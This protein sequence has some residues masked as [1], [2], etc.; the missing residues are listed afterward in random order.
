[1]RRR[2]FVAVSSSALYA[3][4]EAHVGLASAWAQSP[5]KSSHL[6]SSLRLLTTSPISVM[7][8]FYE[9]T[10]GL[11]ILKASESNLLIQAG[12]ST[13]TFEKIVSDARPFYHFAFNIPENKIEQAFAWQRNRTPIVHPNPTGPR[14]A[15]VHFRHWNAHS[16]FF[17]D[18]AGNLLEYIARHDLKNNANGDFSSNDILYVSEIGFIVDE[19]EETGNSIQQSLNLGSYRPSE[20]FIPIG[21]ENGLLLMIKKGRIWSSN[22][23]QTN[24]VDVFKTSVSIRNSIVSGWKS[25][26]Y[27]Y[28][29][30]IDK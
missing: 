29:I 28:E 3:M 13:I 9:K 19:V 10:L 23:N 17:L 6:I 1:M 24:E 25:A 18:P 11:K 4:F 2:D 30:L 20:N 14:D 26:N 21:D 12:A 22:P 15:V 16:I 8:N 7:R 27:P 5:N